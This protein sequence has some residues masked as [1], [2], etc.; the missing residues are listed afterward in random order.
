MKKTW[1]VGLVICAAMSL[2]V[3]APVFAC[4][5][6]NGNAMEGVDCVAADEEEDE[7][8]TG[9]GLILSVDAIDYGYLSELGRTY[10]QTFT[11]E[12][13]STEVRA[14]RVSAEKPDTDKIGD[15]AKLAADWLAFVGGVHYFE[16]PAGESKVV[17][18]RVTVP[19]DAKSG[20]QYAVIKIEDTTAGETKEL[21][22]RMTVATDGLAF[23][24]EVVKN[25]ATP[26]GLSDKVHA[27]VTVKNS[28]NAGFVATYSVRV[29]PRFGLQEWQDVVSGETQEV[30]SGAETEFTVGDEDAA[31]GY[32][33]FTVEQRIVYVNSDGSQVEEVSTRTVL[34]VPVWLMATIGGVLA[35]L[36]LLIAIL[37]IVKK[38]KAEDAE[39]PRVVASKKK[40][41]AEQLRTTAKKT[42][43]KIEIQM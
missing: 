27:G 21:S 4:V 7:A 11:I 1:L 16:I 5:D 8:A 38:K 14:I 22:V 24:G 31:I 10:T 25:Y 23:G 13:K 26:V 6:E 15:D 30:Y 2:M 19:V 12:N 33:I 39:R 37:G 18:M 9:E 36:I 17:S 34:N 29:S 32:G 41:N 28:G 40:E 35:I 20:S 42:K 43:K 3:M